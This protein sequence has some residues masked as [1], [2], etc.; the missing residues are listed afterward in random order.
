[1]PTLCCFKENLQLFSLEKMKKVS[2]I[3]HAYKLD[4]VKLALLSVG[5]IGMTVSELKNF[6]SPRGSTTRYR[7]NEY[8][9]D[10]VPKLKIEAVIE[11]NLV[12]TVV[13]EISLA[14]RTG[15][16]G[17]GKIFVSPIA[18]IIR[19]RTGERGITAI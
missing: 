19:I 14:A 10:F 6:G 12:D 8:K 4:N 15:N 1:M 16:I 2:A 18:E 7:G 5:V 17:D 13:Q 3:I 11:D 9:V